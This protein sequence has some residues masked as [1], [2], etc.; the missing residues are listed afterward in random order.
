[1]AIQ[2]ML[3]GSGAAIAPDGH[4]FFQESAVTG[5]AGAFSWLCPDGVTSVSV[6]CIGAGGGGGGANPGSGKG[7]GGAACSYKNNIT[8]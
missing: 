2:Q 7:G 6:V 8:F 3:L 5:V 1:M 4:A